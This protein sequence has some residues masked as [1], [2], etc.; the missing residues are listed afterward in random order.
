MQLAVLEHNIEYSENYTSA[1]A[2]LQPWKDF[3]SYF[4]GKWE[5]WNDKKGKSQANLY[6]Q[7]TYPSGMK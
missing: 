4:K 1:Y 5:Q 2:K 3:E 6:I 7:W